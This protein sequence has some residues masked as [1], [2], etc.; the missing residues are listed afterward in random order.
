MHGIAAPSPEVVPAAPAWLEESAEW[1]GS[2]E[3]DGGPPSGD[4]EWLDD[5][6]L[7]DEERKAVG[8]I[9]APRLGLDGRLYWPVEE[10]GGS[11]E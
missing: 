7:S 11:H 4:A 10:L 8:Q 3:T 9:A 2:R 6:L 1:D 5:E